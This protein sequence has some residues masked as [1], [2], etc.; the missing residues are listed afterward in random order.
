MSQHIT[1]SKNTL[2]LLRFLVRYPITWHSIGPDSRRAARR[3]AELE[4][5]DYD[6]ATHQARLWLNRTP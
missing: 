4:L 3:L 6:S 1:M 2:R 5:V